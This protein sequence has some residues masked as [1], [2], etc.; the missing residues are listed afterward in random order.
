[1]DLRGKTVLL[2]G[3]TGG[4]GRA[5]A[6][7][8]ARRSAALVLSSRKSAELDELARSLPGEGH[9]WIVRDLDEQGAAEGLAAEAG[10]VDVLV[11]NA[12]IG[13]NGRFESF[14]AERIERLVRVN[15]AVPM[16]LARAL[17]PAMRER[18][19]GQ[20]V[21]ISSLAGKAVS[22]RSALYSATKAGLRAFALGLRQDL[23]AA[24]VGVSVVN[25][26]FVREAGMYHESGRT[27]PLGL[28]TTTPARVGEAVARAIEQDRAEVDVAPI[29]QRLLA[30]FAGRRPHVAARI[31]RGRL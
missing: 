16:L 24:G 29:Q 18:G 20:L 21:F 1:V 30:N 6:D 9:R 23:G 2:T 15:L 22:G 28:G 26:G 27:P 31:A 8:L 14:E 5:I 19:A 12:G 3:A 13:G 17:A 7:S 10:T 4:L 25:P 11:A